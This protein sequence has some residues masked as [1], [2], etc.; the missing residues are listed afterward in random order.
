MLNYTCINPVWSLIKWFRYCTYFSM[1]TSGS[2]F[3]IKALQAF[4]G[5]KLFVVTALREHVCWVNRKKNTTQVKQG[6]NASGVGRCIWLK[7]VCK[8]Q[9][10]NEGNA[11][12]VVEPPLSRIFHHIGHD[13][14]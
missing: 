14:K 7:N 1:M 2:V 6:G 4:C 5:V 13:H 9:R 3:F 11:R 12:L 10:V 8:S